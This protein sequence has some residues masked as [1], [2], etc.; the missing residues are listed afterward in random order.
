MNLWDEM[1]EYDG[2]E[3]V[4]RVERGVI[5]EGTS[6]SQPAMAGLNDQIMQFIGTRIMRRW[7]ATSEPPTV[8]SVEVKVSVG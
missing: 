4:F 7:D 1:M 5:E 6:F 8:V 3:M 2:E